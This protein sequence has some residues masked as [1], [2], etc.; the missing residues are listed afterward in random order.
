MRVHHLNCATMLPILPRLAHGK[1]P[2]ELR[3]LVAHCLLIEGADGLILVDSG[4]GLEDVNRG[5]VTRTLRFLARP[6]LDEGET[7]IRQVEALGFK[8]TDVRHIICTHLD[9]DHA[10]G[11]SDFPHA[12]VHVLEAEKAAAMDPTAFEKHRYR[13]AQWAH[14]VDWVTHPETGSPWNGFEAVRDLP[15]LPPEI[16][17]VPTIGHTRGHLSV[18][19][20]GPNGWLLHAGDN[21]YHRGTID[22]AV[23]PAPFGMRLFE[24]ITQTDAERLRANQ[25]RLGELAAGG[26]VQVFSAH[27][28]AEFAA[29]CH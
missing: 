22:P 12:K 16:L 5:R 9:L 27:D 11:L 14:G 23:G 2:P 6:T 25:A 18:A 13:P 4:F 24:R 7:A 1:V 3:K 21:Y 10:G 28:A 29:C 26:E 20:D 15:G 19:I 17:L 8:A